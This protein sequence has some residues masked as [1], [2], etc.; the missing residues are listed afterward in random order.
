MRFGFSGWSIH[1][2]APKLEDL[3][4]ETEILETGIKVIDLLEPYSKG[5]KTGL[6]GGAGVDKT[7]LIMELINNIAIHRGG[8]SVFCV[9]FSHKDSRTWVPKRIP[10]MGYTLNLGKPAGVAWLI[11]FLVGIPAFIIILT[12]LIDK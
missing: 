8:F 9:Y 1:G 4:V 5:G 3:N 2:E 7:V 11:G 6:F 10:W 12:R